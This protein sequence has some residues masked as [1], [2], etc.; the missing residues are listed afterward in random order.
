MTRE[1]LPLRRG[2]VRR[3]RRWALQV[4]VLLLLGASLAAFGPASAGGPTYIH[5]T[6]SGDWVVEDSPYIVLGPTEIPEGQTLF[7]HAGVEVRFAPGASLVAHGGLIVFGLETVPVLLTS[8]RTD[9]SAGDWQGIV[10]TGLSEHSLRWAVVEYAST[11]VSV[12]L[13][14]DAAVTDTEIRFCQVAGIS[15]EAA[16]LSAERVRVQDC[17]VGLHATESAATLADSVLEYNEW[18]GLHA[19][20]SELT[21][22]GSTIKG[23]GYGAVLVSSVLQ[24]DNSSVADSTFE[25]L[26]LEGASTVTA[27]ASVV[28]GEVLFG[29]LG[30]TMHVHWYV[31]AEVVD[32]YGTGIPEAGVRITDNANGTYDGTFVTGAEGRTEEVLVLARVLNSEGGVEYAPFKVRATVGEAFAEKSAFLEGNELVTVTVSIDRTPPSV[33]FGSS[34]VKVAE[35]APATLDGSMSF[36]GDPAFPTGAAFEWTFEDRGRS[37]AMA[38]PVVSYT[39]DTPGDVIVTL[40]VTDA[41]GNVGSGTMVV[42]VLDLT[43]PVADAGEDR[44]VRV[45]E[46]VT[47]D[48][49]ASSDNDPAFP[50]GARYVWTFPEGELATLYGVAPAV[51][52]AEPGRY[53][54]ALA[55]ED[56]AGNVGTDEVLITVK[57]EEASPL[58]PMAVAGAILFA[59]A[60][61]SSTEVGKFGLLKLLFVPLYVKLRRKDVLDH[62]LR[63]QIYGYVRVHPGDTYTDIKRNLGLKNGTLT[64]HLGVLLRE[65]LIKSRTS[66]VNKLFYPADSRMPE[67]GMALH[68]IQGMILERVRESPGISASDLA[69]VVGVSRQLVNYHVRALVAMNL[70]RVERRGV[71]NRFYPQADRDRGA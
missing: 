56:A 58:V 21:V 20:A 39:F 13:G 66:G 31:G 46:D 50:R 7:I 47:L 38:G 22:S 61:V 9:G 42:R 43:P 10:L 24:L 30:S 67:D 37:V 62:F 52:F 48:A 49:S 19:L 15:V 59:A 44:V 40:T 26:S 60:A 54:I 35:D 18:G 2:K 71:R 70:V 64:Y 11:G 51:R 16:S 41:A 12:E 8:N 57:A 32:L 28:V 34:L 17:G 65:G 55:V 3:T 69:A 14:A 63:G 33:V 68:A 27:V 29:D 53:R 4:F 36:D 1:W 45:G 5:T 23:N 6:A 25:A